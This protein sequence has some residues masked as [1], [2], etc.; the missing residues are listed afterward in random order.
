MK[1]RGL[2]R[3]RVAG[4]LLAMV[5]IVA[6]PYLATRVMADETQQAN[7]W[8]NHASKVKALTY[9]IAYLIRDSEAAGYRI[10]AGDGD[11]ATEQRAGGTREQVPALLAQLRSLTRDNPD[12]QARIGALESVT[13]GRMTL[14][15]QALAR[16]RKGDAAG[17]R[18][19]LRDTGDLFHMHVLIDGIAQQQFRR[20]SGGEAQ[21]LMLARAIASEPGLLL[22]DEPTAQLDLPTARTV[23]ASLGA[24]R[25]PATII[26][27]A[28]HDAA[29]RDSCSDH[30]DLTLD[31]AA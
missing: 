2:L 29:T 1:V 6:L 28:T 18:Q 10:L 21:R 8:L 4:L 14:V 23:N 16:L 22:V 11:A 9:R 25:S 30:V 5:V 13:N 26:V 31:P 17:A 12:Q 20:L 27:V 3:W 7:L 19:S 24:L 15:E